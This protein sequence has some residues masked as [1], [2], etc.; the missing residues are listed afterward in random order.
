MIALIKTFYIKKRRNEVRSRLE[1]YKDLITGA[2]K[3]KGKKRRPKSSIILDIRKQIAEELNE[4]ED[5][6]QV[7]LVGSRI[8]I[9]GNKRKIAVTYMRE[10][11][12]ENWR[13]MKS[14][15]EEQQ[16]ARVIIRGD[17][18][19]RTGTEGG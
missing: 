19:T 18:N 8:K 2:I 6:I 14:W 9:K 12:G 3:T 7:E 1:D 5:F 11:G 10:K 15:S 17:C 13:K 16:E 4:E